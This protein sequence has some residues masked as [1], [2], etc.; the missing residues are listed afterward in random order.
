MPFDTAAEFARPMHRRFVVVICYPSR[1]ATLLPSLAVIAFVATLAVAGGAAFAAVPRDAS[2]TLSQL[3]LSAQRTNRELLAAR[4]AIDMGRARLV[5]A[6]LLPNPRVNVSIG[7]GYLLGNRDAYAM[8]VGVSQDFPMTGRIL[9][10]QDVARV[11]VALAD[12][13]I[14]EA[15]RRLAGEVA[16]GVYR[17][18]IIE[19][20]INTTDALIAIDERLAK[21]TRN[22]YKAAEVSELD[23]NAVAIDVRR[24]AQERA[25]LQTQH[26]T[27]RIALNLALGRAPGSPLHLAE[28]PLAQESLDRIGESGTW[29]ARRPDYAMAMLQVDRSTAEIALAKAKRWDDWSVGVG[30]QQDRQPVD[31]APAQGNDRALNL[32]LTIPL[33]LNSR[34]RGLIAVA[35]ANTD[36]QRARLVAQRLAIENQ[37]ASAYAAAT[38][39]G[40]VLSDYRKELLPV[41]ERNVALAQKGYAQGLVTILEVVQAQRQLGDVQSSYLTTFDQYLQERV[42]LHVAVSDYP[43]LSQSGDTPREQNNGPREEPT[44]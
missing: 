37:V 14:A 24:L 44:Q 9:R 28:I 34:S 40:A 41:A 35:A 3:I 2:E 26:E 33:S 27:Q 13:E 4:Y 29:L 31:G 19:R 38:G 23:V 43:L 6:G 32:T 39:L 18:L 1:Q 5:Q 25:R 22:R 11:D 30:V 20:Q 36:Q 15:E 17:M 12:A 10:Q 8:A 42:R 16:S 21:S 7:S